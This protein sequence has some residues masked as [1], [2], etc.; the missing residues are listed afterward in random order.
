MVNCPL[1]ER[2]GLKNVLYVIAYDLFSMTLVQARYF[3]YNTFYFEIFHCFFLV[4]NEIMILFEN[5]FQKML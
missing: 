2:L 3:Q 4:K 5:L 1:H